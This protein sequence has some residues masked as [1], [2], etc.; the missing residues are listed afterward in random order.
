[1][2]SKIKIL[3]SH[4]LVV[5]LTLGLT[6]C[7]LKLGEVFAPPAPAK[8]EGASCI[9]LSMKNLKTYFGGEASDDQVAESLQC[10][11]DVFIA[12]K[13]N[14]RGENKD[15]YTAREI[16]TFVESNFLKTTG[17]S[18]FSDHLLLEIMKFKVALVGGNQQ[19]VRKDEIDKV[20]NL[21]ALFK[22]DL[23]RIN[24]SMKILTFQW[25]PA[26]LGL[27][28]TEKETQFLKAKSDFLSLIKKISLQ[29]ET[30]GKA[31]QIDDMVDFVLELST[32]AHSNKATLDTIEKARP[33]IKKFKL[34]LI[35]GDSSLQNK[36]WS[37]LGLT[38]NEGLF[39]VLRME[40][41][42]NNLQPHDTKARWSGYQKIAI[43]LSELLETLLITKETKT[44]SNFEIA[45]L[46]ETLNNIYP[47]L[48]LSINLWDSLGYIKIMLLGDSP[49]G[50]FG[51]SPTDFSALR[52][53]IPAL[54][55]Q[56]AIVVTTY[57]SI[58]NEHHHIRSALSY[59]EFANAEKQILDAVE[60]L[61]KL[62]ERPYNI[63][64]LKS[65]LLELSHGPLKET[66]ILPEN[67]EQLFNVALN[68][69]T[70]ITG[71]A[72][73][74]LKVENFR[75]LIKVGVR[76]FFNYLEYD[77][78][79][80]P[81]QAESFTF[82]ANL[83][84]LAESTKRTIN[85][86]LSSKSN[87]FYSNQEITPLILSLQTEK[88]V[89]THLQQASLENLLNGLWK[90]IL[91]LPELRLSNKN[92]P[93]FDLISLNIVM[94]EFRRFIR[95]QKFNYSVFESS[96]VLPKPALLMAIN[97]G[98][99]LN[100]DSL[101]TVSLQE[102]KQVILTNV[103]LN[104]DD[105]GFLKIMT[106]DLGQYHLIDQKNS[107]IAR[108]LARIL[109]RGYAQNLLRVQTLEGIDLSEAQMALSQFKDVILDLNLV[110]SLGDGFMASRF[111][112]S[113]LFLTTS[114]GNSLSSFS[115]IH[116]LVL[117]IISGMSRANLIRT[118]VIKLCSPLMTDFDIT[119]P[120]V[121]EDCLIQFYAHEIESF[122]NLPGFLAMRNQF[123]EAE[124][125]DHYT[126]LLKAAGYVPNDKRLVLMSDADLFP[127]VVQYIEMVFQ[128]F[129]LNGDQTL[130]KDEALSAF[131]VYHDLIKE[132][133]KDYNLKE[134]ELPGVFIYLLK[135]SKP[136]KTIPEKI[137][138]KLF[139]NNPTK[140]IIQSSRIDL[141]KI[142][143]FIADSMKPKTAVPVNPEPAAGSN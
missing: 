99:A 106:A 107:N 13:E 91:N 143:N 125:K 14:I 57:E 46:A 36:E 4:F 129:D 133:T 123:S 48:S 49:S 3:T 54:F 41:F 95:L 101:L 105:H 65:L 139:I 142:F 121:Q 134:S 90:N 29:F 42:L 71:Q 9:E 43:D 85:F 130:D 124:L 5:I 24:K 131:P 26:S 114:D 47:D 62:A 63:Y 52:R 81:Y 138:F 132:L 27:T 28:E 23:I 35:G 76:G 140:W 69:K 108:S 15:T 137:Q 78:F 45:E 88:I 2:Y 115:E 120:A 53:K 135:Y 116:Q 59:A 60:N 73:N 22:P 25:Q 50:R 111:L 17:P 89:Q 74:N 127:H 96:P 31:Y 75:L 79:L 64:S 104:F 10:L 118:K 122:S 77:L 72:D 119:K 80:K 21:I 103:S 30:V 40:Y 18:T 11:Q 20:S 128:R 98:I 8:V 100:Q 86:N 38:L 83:E 34:I 16:V 82:L 97:K 58:T 66:L 113:N 51:W 126:S 19:V 37:Q 112:E 12:F 55:E 70:L 68:G 117:H 61:S 136:P 102:T 33:F 110:D 39:Q 56:L 67:F 44:L 141:G 93:G 87:P 1:M 109:I 7:G 92:R 6:G 94:D 84:R 32:A